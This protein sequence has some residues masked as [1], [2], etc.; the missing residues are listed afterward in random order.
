MLTPLVM[1]VAEH[2]CEVAT[3]DVV[4][5]G[6]VA[7]LDGAQAHAQVE[8][9]PAPPCLPMPIQPPPRPIGK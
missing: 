3:L 5:Q 7:Y 9:Q 2:Y 4:H 6:E 8:A 1:H